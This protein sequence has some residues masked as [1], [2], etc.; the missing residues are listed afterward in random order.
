MYWSRLDGGKIRKLHVNASISIHVRDV[1]DHEGI[2]DNIKQIMVT[3][4][5]LKR[6]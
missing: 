1:H 4:N 6:S 3:E 5:M 2:A